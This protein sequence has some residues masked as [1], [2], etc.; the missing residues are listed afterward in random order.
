MIKLA[1]YGCGNRTKQ[2]LDALRSD[3]F[4]CVHAAFDVNMQAAEELVA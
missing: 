1:L 4:Y 2:L 3:E